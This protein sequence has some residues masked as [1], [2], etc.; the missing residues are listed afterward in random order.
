MSIKNI[1]LL[2]LL[3]ITLIVS[4]CGKNELPLRVGINN[5]PETLDPRKL[6]GRYDAL[7]AKQLFECLTYLDQSGAVQPAAAESWEAL[8]GDT[9]YVFHLRKN[10]K[11]SD[12]SSVTAADFAYAW[13]THLDPKFASVTADN[14]YFIKNAE[15]YNGGKCQLTEVGIKTPD[16]YTIEVELEQPTPFFPDLLSSYYYAPVCKRVLESDSA[17]FNSPTK[18]VCNGAFKLKSWSHNSKIEIVKN[19]QYWNGSEV[20]LD[21]AEFVITENSSTLLQ[22]LESGQLDVLFN[23]PLSEMPRLMSENKLKIFPLLGTYFY[24]FN[25]Q[26]PPFN[27][28]RVRQALCLAIDRKTIVDKVLKGGQQPALA[29][30][31]PGIADY[32]DGSDFRAVG[33]DYFKDNDIETA[34]KLLA[35]AGYPDGKGFPVDAV[36]YNTAD[37]HK[38]MAEAIQEM[39]R[40]NLGIKTRLTNMEGKV[41]LATRRKYDY[42][43]ARDGW[44]ADYADPYTFLSLFCEQLGAPKANFDDVTFD[45]ILMS[46]N[47]TDNKRL[48]S[49]LLHEAENTLMQAFA[50]VPIYYYTDTLCLSPR[51][52]NFNHNSLGEV[53]LKTIEIN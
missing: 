4:G 49:K 43:I 42:A 51:V 53:F 22:M 31:P 45:T 12:G 36:L 16:D 26:Q 40:T 21:N 9:K 46:S 13:R 5:E 19:E 39:W 18:I 28:A 32:Q 37:E 20:T 30:V 34:R 24:S 23:P 50:I 3:L 8:D 52:K 44:T 15:R 47:K 48:R 11:W 27:D 1:L 38:Q 7:V 6:S 33:G 41:F 10:A 29:L 25:T 17:T 14:L 35:A 2:S